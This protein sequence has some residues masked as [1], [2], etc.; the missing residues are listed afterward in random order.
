MKGQRLTRL[1]SLTIIF[2]LFAI[3]EEL[4]SRISLNSK[5]GCEA[6]VFSGVHFTEFDGRTFFVQDS[7]SLGVFRSKGFAVTT[8]WS[9]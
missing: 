3:N 6:L 7:S 1:F 5:L 4:E 9:I 8:P 2:S